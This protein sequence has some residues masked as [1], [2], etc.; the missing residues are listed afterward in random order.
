[1]HDEYRL[2]S[3][4]LAQAIEEFLDWQALHRGRSPEH[5]TTTKREGVACL[6]TLTIPVLLV[7][8]L[9]KITGP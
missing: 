3:P 4:T 7:G 9:V 5:S 1:V 6:D 2:T 8:W